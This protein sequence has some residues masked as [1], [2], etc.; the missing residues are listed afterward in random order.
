[1]TI[2][3]TARHFDARPEL[4]EFAEDSVQRLTQMYDGIVSAD[5]VFDQEPHGEGKIVE[6]GLLVARDKLFA[7]EQSN[8]FVASVNACIEKLERQLVRH[9]E[10]F[11]E[12][13]HA[14]GRAEVD[15]SSPD[16]AM[17]SDDLGE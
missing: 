17:A 3:F 7:K 1:M 9:K 5:I 16:D 15:T 6:I 12:A 4:Q 13:R 2:Q 14:R 11:I 8:D 10:K